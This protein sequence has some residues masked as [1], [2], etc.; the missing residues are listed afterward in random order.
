MKKTKKRVN[1]IFFCVAKK[2][3][4]LKL[5]TQLQALSVIYKTHAIYIKC[6]M[7]IVKGGLHLTDEIIKN[8]F[9]KLKNEFSKIK[10]D[11]ENLI[12]KCKN[13]DKEIIN[14]VYTETMKFVNKKIDPIS[15]FNDKDNWY[16]IILKSLDDFN[17]EPF[18]TK[19]FLKSYKIRKIS[20]NIRPEKIKNKPKLF[21]IN[22]SMAEFFKIREDNQII[23]IV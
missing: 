15:C 4:A 18:K 19:Y 2:D 6:F 10:I 13:K 9:S 11:L 16:E 3:L 23:K 5:S 22:I 1:V 21:W 12:V 20:R 14:N 8:E 17:K 7:Y